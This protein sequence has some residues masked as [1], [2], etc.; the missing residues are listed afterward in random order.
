MND[1]GGV[2]EILGG[3]FNRPTADVLTH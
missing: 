1:R 3:F 2:A